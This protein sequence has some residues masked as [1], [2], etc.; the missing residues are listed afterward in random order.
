MKLERGMAKAKHS[1]QMAMSMK[2]NMPAEKGM[3]MCESKNIINCA[4]KY[5]VTTS[6]YSPMS[7]NTMMTSRPSAR[8]RGE[9][10]GY[11]NAI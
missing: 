3:V 7:Q 10:S 2:E 8:V 6:C 1:C 5:E 9:G 11:N 4:L